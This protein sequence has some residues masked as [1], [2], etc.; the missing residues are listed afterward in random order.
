MSTSKRK[1]ERG[2]VYDI[3]QWNKMK[4]ELKNDLLME[5]T[6]DAEFI[7]N[8]VRD[9][10]IINYDDRPGWHPYSD[11]V[12]KKK[13]EEHYK[14]IGENVYKKISARLKELEN[15]RDTKRHRTGH[16]GG[17]KRRK[18][19]RKSRRRMRRKSKGRKRRKS[20]RK[21]KR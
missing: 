7:N 17:K 15:Q 6:K 4:N 18:S 13:I 21:R 5:S 10:Q 2:R 12:M 8:L 19:R 3:E 16:I 20:R 14:R 1:Q 9:I 11:K